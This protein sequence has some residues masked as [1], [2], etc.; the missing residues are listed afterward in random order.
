[1]R[2]PSTSWLPPLSCEH[3]S[4]KDDQ[5]V[6][7]KIWFSEGEKYKLVQQLRRMKRSNVPVGVNSR[8]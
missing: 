8:C 6:T 2:L 5:T 1:M 4:G 7:I 3:F